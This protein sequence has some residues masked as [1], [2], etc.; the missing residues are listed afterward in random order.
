MKEQVNNFL[1]KGYAHFNE[2]KLI[3]LSK[4][5]ITNVEIDDELKNDF[6]PEEKILIDNFVNYVSENYV[7][8]IYKKFDVTYYSIWDGVDIGSTKWHNDSVEGFDFNVL[9]YFDDTNE[10]VGGS[11][12][13][14]HSEGDDIIYPKSGDLVFIN[15]NGKFFHK[16]SRSKNPRRVASIEYKVYE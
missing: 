12:E 3:D 4:F 13:F 5:K 10:E 16:A 7:K 1:T 14:R 2:S 15:Q 11:I 9:Y 8:S 6:T